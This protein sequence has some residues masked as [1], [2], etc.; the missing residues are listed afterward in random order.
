[1]KSVCRVAWCPRGAHRWL[2]SHIFQ[3]VSPLCTV[4]CSLQPDG[5]TLS[6]FCV[7]MPRLALPTL[8]GNVTHWHANGFGRLKHTNRVSCSLGVA[9]TW[10]LESPDR[11]WL[12]CFPPQK[13][14]SWTG[15]RRGSHPKDGTPRGTLFRYW[16]GW[17]AVR[18]FA[19]QNVQRNVGFMINEKRSWRL[20]LCCAPVSLL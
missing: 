14:S 4:S 1:M 10:R 13:W 12:M 17:V 2:C 6:K 18:L 5:F 16:H 3:H 9:L 8:Q 19:Q 20:T 7:L 15:T 11:P